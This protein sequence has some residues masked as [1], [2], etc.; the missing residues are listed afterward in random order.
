MLDRD[1]LEL[2]GVEVE[3][4]F[5]GAHPRHGRAS[6]RVDELVAAMADD[7]ERVRAILGVTAPLDS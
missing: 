1:D 4:S 7:V 5:V 3:V 2:Y 6:T